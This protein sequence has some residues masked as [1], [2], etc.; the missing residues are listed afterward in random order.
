MHSANASPSEQQLCVPSMALHVVGMGMSQ[1]SPNLLNPELTAASAC[2]SGGNSV[3]PAWLLV[4]AKEGVNLHFLE[5]KVVF[6]LC[7]G[8]AAEFWCRYLGL[9]SFAK[10]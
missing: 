10:L 1:G 6:C 2:P 9:E 7:L 4:M 8:F 5:Y 3:E